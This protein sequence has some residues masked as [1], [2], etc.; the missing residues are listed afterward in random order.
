MIKLNPEIKSMAN[1]CQL[2]FVAKDVN[3]MMDRLAAVGIGPFQV[4]SMDTRNMRGVNYR[5]A[6]ADYALKV[7]MAEM[8]SWTVEIIVPVRGGKNIYT[9][10]LEKQ[11]E[12]GLHHLGTYMTPSEYDGAYQYLERLGYR[13]IQGGPINGNDRQGRFDYFEADRQYGILLELLDMPE[14]YGQPDYVYP[15]R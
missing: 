4:Y 5:G 14:V 1:W 12:G 9:E 6:P 7:A 10:Y 11:P 8:G 2:G 15:E 13:Q 3:V